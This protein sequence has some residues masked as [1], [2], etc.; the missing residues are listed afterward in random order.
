[1]ILNSE[2]LFNGYGMV[3][4]S[5]MR[6][7]NLSIEVKGVYAYLC[8]F[9]GAGECVLP[10][11]LEQCKELGI[12]QDKYYKCIQILIDNGYLEGEEN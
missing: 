4:R 9:S 3:Q 8:S 5:I 11:V 10:D 6:D 1:M 7:P 12:S 2:G